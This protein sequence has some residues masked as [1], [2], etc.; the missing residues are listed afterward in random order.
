M[1]IKELI[2]KYPDGVTVNGCHAFHFKGDT[3]G[4]VFTFV[5]D[6]TRVFPTP[7]DLGKIFEEWLAFFDGDASAVCEFLREN[8][9]KIKVEHVPLKKF[10]MPYTKAIIL[11]E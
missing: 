6:S 10:P 2:E 8:P 11:E 1:P 5:E 3:I 4:T 7:G 9:I